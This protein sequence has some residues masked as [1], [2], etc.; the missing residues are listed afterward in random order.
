MR[1][2]SIN[3][4]LRRWGI[5]DELCLP[6]LLE[7]SVVVTDHNRSIRV[8]VGRHSNSKHS[9]VHAKCQNSYCRSSENRPENN[10]PDPLPKLLD[11]E[12][13]HEARL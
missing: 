5:E 4:G 7:H 8:P 2:Q 6:V 10:S 11:G 1:E 12:L 13:S 9:E 3:A